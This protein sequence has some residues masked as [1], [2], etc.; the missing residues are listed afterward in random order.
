[1][2]PSK[3]MVRMIGA[4]V[5]GIALA[6][7]TADGDALG[8]I[9]TDYPRPAASRSASAT[10][11]PQAMASP[12]PDASPSPVSTVQTGQDVVAQVVTTDLVVR[13]AP[14]VSADSEIYPETLDAPT[15]LFVVDGPSRADG[16]DWYLVEPFTLNICMDLCPPRL[17]F[18]WVAEAGTDGEPW[19]APAT[20]ECP[21]PEPEDIGWLTP[22]AR[23]ACYG[24]EPLVLK[25]I[26]G[27][28]YAAETPVSL[29][30]T[31]C[32]IRPTDYVAGDGFQ[33]HL[34]MRSADGVDLP[35]DRPGTRIEAT[36]H[37]D[38][39]SAANC[40]WSDTFNDEGGNAPV[41]PQPPALVILSCRTEF[42]VT[43]IAVVDE[44]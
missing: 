38:D 8:A 21:E 23:L 44:P 25:G 20:L 24:G 16:F 15:L 37:F 12:S 27:N 41:E 42:V 1:M 19:I 22:V 3:G 29:Q 36:G 26:V 7:C 11:S 32:E 17:P 28:C 13:S 31:G 2:A 9:A 40:Q 30:Q 43:D 39:A 4:F 5:I 18:G 35:S 34:I 14:G 33:S 6:G 10:A